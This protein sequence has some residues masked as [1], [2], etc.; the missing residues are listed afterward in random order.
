LSGPALERILASP[1]KKVFLTDTIPVQDKV[2]Q[3][4]RLQPLSVSHLL[5]EAIRRINNAE[6]VSSLFV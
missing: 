4:D 2:A 6:S 1:L 3:C 5:A